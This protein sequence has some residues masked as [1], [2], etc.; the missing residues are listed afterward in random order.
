MHTNHET[1]G[2]NKLASHFFLSYIH[3]CNDDDNNYD[4]NSDNDDNN[5]NDDNE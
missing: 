4:D 3:V 5:N 1:L 2:G